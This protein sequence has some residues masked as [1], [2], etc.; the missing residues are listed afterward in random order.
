MVMDNPTIY[1]VPRPGVITLPLL[2]GAACDEVLAYV[3][4][5]DDWKPAGIISEEGSGKVAT[6]IRAA[7]LAYVGRDTVIGRLLGRKMDEVVQPILREQWQRELPEYEVIQIVRYP[8]GGF[9]RAHRDSG[10]QIQARYFSL[11]CYL[12]DDF[13]GGGTTFCDAGYTVVPK[14]GHAVLFPADFLHRAEPVVEGTKYIAVTWF[15]GDAPI[16][17]I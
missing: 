7:T 11:V 12:N 10:E 8:P 15:R 17:W 16:R 5:Q 2:D 14:Q 9:Y 4:A 1:S 6:D 13:A 3:N